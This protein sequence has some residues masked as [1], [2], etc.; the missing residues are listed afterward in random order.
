MA[1]ALLVGGDITEA[2]AVTASQPAL[3]EARPLSKNAYKLPIFAA[4]VRRAI[5]AAAT[6][7]TLQT[8]R[9]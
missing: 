6:P 1:E 3:A 8:R 2:K 7:G 5:L 9:S 4:L